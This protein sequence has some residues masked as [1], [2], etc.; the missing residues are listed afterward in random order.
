MKP[1]GDLIKHVRAALVK[2]FGEP[3]SYLTFENGHML[4]DVRKFLQTPEG[5]KS[6]EEAIELS[7]KF[8]K[9]PGYQEYK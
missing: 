9:A 7:N 5:K 4:L 3:R 2:K 6:L 1:E 8:P